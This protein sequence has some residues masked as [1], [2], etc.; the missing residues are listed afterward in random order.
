MSNNYQNEDKDWSDFYKAIKDR[1]PR[2]TLL[3]ALTFFDK[4]EDPGKQY[5]A[6]D[7]GC[8]TGLDTFELLRR[9]WKVFA[10]DKEQKAIDIIR[11]KV[12]EDK[13]ENLETAAVAF[14]E[15]SFKSADL[16]NAG[17]SLPFCNPDKFD[18]VWENV[19]NAIKINGRFSGNFFGEKDE[20]ANFDDM[21]FHTKDKLKSMFTK[22]EIEFFHER[23][24]DGETATGIKKHWHVFSVVARKIS[25]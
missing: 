5:Y 24:E 3:E 15:L 14:H 25:S 21:T 4:D 19:V 12:T 6:M 17:M 18:K 2:E 7:I 1:P 16:I 11:E 9:G 10:T 20:W 13:K 8:G 23:D 22:F